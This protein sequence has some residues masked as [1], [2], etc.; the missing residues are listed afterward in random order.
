MVI[1]NY[2]NKKY[3]EITNDEIIFYKWYGKRRL[4][5]SKIRAAFMNDEYKITILYGKAIRKFNV[6]NVNKNEKAI[7]GKLIEIMNGEEIVF[8]IDR[9]GNNKNGL[10]IL[11]YILAIEI[12]NIY[13][14]NWQK[15]FLVISAGIVIFLID[16]YFKPYYSIFVYDY[17]K[18]YITLE[19]VNSKKK[20]EFTLN[21]DKFKFEY[22]RECYSYKFKDNKGNN[23][24]IP[25]N[26]IY[27]IYYKE[28]LAE[29][30]ENTMYSC[31]K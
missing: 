4:K 19:S 14:N 1:N 10:F 23:L 24:L 28:K 16:I 25:T 22:S 7:L 17:N 6:C 15:I 12:S 18:K 27:P 30:N 20:K 2:N 8:A 9:G 29:L 26:I 31:I 5:R 13:Y 11:T 3:I 21:K